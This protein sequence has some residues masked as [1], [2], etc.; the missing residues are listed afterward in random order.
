MARRWGRAGGD[1]QPGPTA[2]SQP[3]AHSATHLN[4]D[5]RRSRRQEKSAMRAPFSGRETRL[6]TTASS[7]SFFG[8]MNCSRDTPSHM[9]SGLATST[10]E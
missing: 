4:R 1:R 6:Q 5:V 10:E 2:G 8:L 9:T 7:F 3:R